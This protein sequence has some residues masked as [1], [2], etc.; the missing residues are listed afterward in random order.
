[1]TVDAGNLVD[2]VEK[3]VT[4]PVE[5]TVLTECHSGAA[6]RC[7]R[8]LVFALDAR[9]RRSMR[10][11]I[12]IFKPLNYEDLADPKWKGKI[13]I[14]SGQ[15]PYNTALCCRLHR[16]SRRGKRRRNGSPAS[17]LTWPA[18]PAGGDRDGAKDI[19]RRHLR[20]RHRQFL[21]CRPDALGQGRRGTGKP[22]ATPSR[23]SCRPSRT[24]A[25]RSTS[26]ARPSPK[27][28]RTRPKP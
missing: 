10:R 18:R 27:M 5:S 3:G 21:L 19:A 15:H 24:A 9:P 14:R 16:P 28:R 20:Y 4:Q 13:C 12:S 7:K 11:R 26:A 23:S 17:R 6:A 8:Q 1:M 22:G 25:R 2:L